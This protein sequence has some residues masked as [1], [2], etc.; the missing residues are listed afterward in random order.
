MEA[1]DV[2]VADVV[3]AVAV[4]MANEVVVND[5]NVAVTTVDGVDAIICVVLVFVVVVVVV[6]DDDDDDDDIDV[7]VVTLLWLFCSYH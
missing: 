4:N 2:V 5:V 1:V 6:V 7:N 3:F